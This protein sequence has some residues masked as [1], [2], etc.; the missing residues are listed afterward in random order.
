[1]LTRLRYLAVSSECWVPS[2]LPP[3]G[4]ASGKARQLCLQSGDWVVFMGHVPDNTDQQEASP[5]LLNQGDSP[6]GR[7]E[8]L[9]L[10]SATSRPGLVRRLR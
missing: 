8:A 10:S 4:S 6:L 7:P 3:P 2:S 9:G 5:W 1:M